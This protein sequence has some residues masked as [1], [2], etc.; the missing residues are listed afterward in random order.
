MARAGNPLAG[1]GGGDTATKESPKKTTRKSTGNGR[2]KA[3][4]TKA[5]GT[6]QRGRRKA[7]S[8][9]GQARSQY[10]VLEVQDDNM[11]EDLGVFEGQTAQKAIAAYLDENEDVES[12]TFMAISARSF[13]P[14][15]VS[16]AP[17]PPKKVFG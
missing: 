5:S 14:V 10:H 15:E 9:G 1:D 11:L 16:L 7:S 12:G 17:Q 4:T 6:S 13:K 2:R 3:S 8:N